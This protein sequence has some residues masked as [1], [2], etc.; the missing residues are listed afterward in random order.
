MRTFNF[1]YQDISPNSYYR[2]YLH[3]LSCPANSLQEIQKE[4]PTAVII[5]EV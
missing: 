5:C 1:C 3:N 2:F 4:N